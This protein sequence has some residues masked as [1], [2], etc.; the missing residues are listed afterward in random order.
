MY[1]IRNH[2]LDSKLEEVGN[3]SLNLTLIIKSEFANKF[4]IKYRKNALEFKSNEALR[5]KYL[6][7]IDTQF[8]RKRYKVINKLFTSFPI[9]ETYPT[10]KPKKMEV[11][12]IWVFSTED[13][14]YTYDASL[15]GFIL[16]RLGGS[17]ENVDLNINEIG[18]LIF[19]YQ[20]EDVA[21]LMS[22][23]D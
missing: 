5:E 4:K 8:N 16:K 10:K 3:W 22:L 13:A 21:V 17:F 1:S 15:V 18:I 11:K 20:G 9:M 2:I 19:T 23:K 14:K 12:F 6:G 7:I